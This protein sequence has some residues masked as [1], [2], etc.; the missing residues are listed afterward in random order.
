MHRSLRPAALLGL[1]LL[2]ACAGPHP[3]GMPAPRQRDAQAAAPGASAGDDK[4]FSMTP[5]AAPGASAGDDKVFSMT[6]AAASLAQAQ[7][8]VNQS[9]RTLG[10]VSDLEPLLAQARQ[11]AAEGNARRAQQLSA[12]VVSRSTLALDARYAALAELELQKAQT[13]TGLSDA[14]LATVRQAEVAMARGYGR[15]AHA[16]LVALNRELAQASQRYVVAAG[17]S[18]WIISGRPAV[19]GNPQLWPLIWEAN[20][21]T[22]PDPN[23]LRSGLKLKIRANPTIDE[24]VQAIE[25]SRSAARITIGPVR[26]DAR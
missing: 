10:D 18:L 23:R 12:E 8:A 19:Y 4:V 14:Q 15:Q 21:D 24:V 3:A 9:R 6:P 20:L 11:A 16:S 5:A 2:A 22:V 7:R 25:R 26:G 1:A 17:D 13:Y